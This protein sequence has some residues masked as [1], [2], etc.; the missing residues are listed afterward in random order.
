MQQHDTFGLVWGFFVVV[1]VWCVVRAC[2]SGTLPELHWLTWSIAVSSFYPWT[3][4]GI[5]V[6]M[7]KC[8]AAPCEGFLDVLMTSFKS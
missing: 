3:L 8:A 5:M 4:D 2:G 6:G 1:F 7:K